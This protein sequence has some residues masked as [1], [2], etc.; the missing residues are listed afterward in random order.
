MRQIHE[1]TGQAALVYVQFGGLHPAHAG[2]D[3]AV[4]VSKGQAHAR[5]EQ[6]YS[7]IEAHHDVPC[8]AATQY[9]GIRIGIGTIN[10][11]SRAVE[12]DG[13]EEGNG[14]VT[15]DFV[16]QGWLEQE[17]LAGFIY[18]KGCSIET[19]QPH[20]YREEAFAGFRPKKTFVFLC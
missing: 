18:K 7:G 6:V 17:T 14:T 8:A 10:E 3:A 11:Y 4:A 13:K 5:H 2:E 15:L 1:P 12:R 20:Q 16:D 9:L 19:E